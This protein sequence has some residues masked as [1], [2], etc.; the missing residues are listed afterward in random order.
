MNFYT[1]FKPLVKKR[2]RLI[3]TCLIMKLVIFIIALTCF[4]ASATGYAQQ[5]T[6]TEKNVSI[7]KVFKAMQK[8]TNYIFWYEDNVLKN[9]SHVNIN[10][11]NVT[12]KEALDKCLEGQPLTYTI[13]GQTVVIKKKP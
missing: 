8:Q 3:K 4:Q 9:A 11:K 2:G 10:L 1:R 13:V 12:L 7:E 5:I 6:L